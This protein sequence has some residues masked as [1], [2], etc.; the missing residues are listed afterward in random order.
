M[1]EQLLNVLENTLDR[2]IT[3]HQL[4][5]QIAKIFAASSLLTVSQQILVPFQVAAVLAPNF[6]LLPLA[7]RYFFKT[8][9]Y[10]FEAAVLFVEAAQHV[11][12]RCRRA[13]PAAYHGEGGTF[14]GVVG[15]Q[16][17]LIWYL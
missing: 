15:R 4:L 7:R 17:V 10:F 11:F 12:V 3:V 9:D 16:K 5:V 13:A 8:A 14:V 1:V 6:A 2:L